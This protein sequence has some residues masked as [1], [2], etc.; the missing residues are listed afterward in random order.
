MEVS[1][2]KRRDAEFQGLDRFV[3][4]EDAAPVVNDGDCGLDYYQLHCKVLAKRR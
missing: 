2:C 4:L 1:G 3:R